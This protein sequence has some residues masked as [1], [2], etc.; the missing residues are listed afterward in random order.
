MFLRS[1]HLV[2]QEQIVLPRRAV[3]A[4]ILALASSKMDFQEDHKTISLNVRFK[5]SHGLV[6][7]LRQIPPRRTVHDRQISDNQLMNHRLREVFWHQVSSGIISSSK[8]GSFSTTIGLFSSLRFFL[9]VQA[10]HPLG[11]DLL[12]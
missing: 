7:R 3:K 10:L 2:G 6:A 5:Y 1:P 12:F 11:P 9:A 8:R 4:A